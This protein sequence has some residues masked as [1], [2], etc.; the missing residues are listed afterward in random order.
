MSGAAV[1]VGGEGGPPALVA[2]STWKGSISSRRSTAR[3][4]L[5]SKA[6]RSRCP[7]PTLPDDVASGDKGHVRENV[8]RTTS[9]VISRTISVVPSCSRRQNRAAPSESLICLST[10]RLPTDRCTSSCET[11]MLLG[12]STMHCTVLLA[13]PV[14]SFSRLHAWA[15]HLKRA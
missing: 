4:V 6:A 14:H 7:A 9:P 3:P 15:S 5:R 13:H 2:A 12:S 1:D 11:R 10:P 8:H